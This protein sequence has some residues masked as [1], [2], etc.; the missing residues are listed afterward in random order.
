MILY[1]IFKNG[2]NNINLNIAV[3]VH[4]PFDIIPNIQGGKDDI[5]P[6]ITLTYTHVELY[7]STTLFLISSWGE[8]DIS[9][10]ISGVLHPPVILFLISRRVED[11][12]TEILQGLYTPFLILFLIPSGKEDDITPNVVEGYN[13][14]VILFL[15]SRGRKDDIISNIAVDI[16]TPPP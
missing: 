3:D 5:T 8:H 12:V 1:L 4:P 16:H 7:T 14:S 13:F 15:V 10:N 11:D 6:N 9:L 2:E